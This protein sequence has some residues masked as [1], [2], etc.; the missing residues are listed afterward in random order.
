MKICYLIYVRNQNNL[1]FVRKPRHKLEEII[2]MDGLG[3]EG[4]E[5]KQGQLY[6]DGHTHEFNVVL[7]R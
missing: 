4:I 6:G 5:L 7:C 1:N 3:P 2:A